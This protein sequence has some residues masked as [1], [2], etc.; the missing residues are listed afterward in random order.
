MDVEQVGEG[1]FVFVEEMLVKRGARDEPAAVDGQ[2]LH[3]RV[4][5]GRQGDF[6]VVQLH[7]AGGG[8]D[9]HPVDGEAG[10]RLGAGAA[11]HRPEAGK[12]F[13]EVEGL[14]DII[15]G[16]MVEPA[17]PVPRAIAGCEHDDGSALAEAEA[18]QHGPTIQPGQH[19]IE[20]DRVIVPGEGFIEAIETVFS[21]VHG[22][23]FL[24]QRLG[25]A[26]QEVGFV[27]D[28]KQAHGG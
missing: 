28:E 12:E 16:P 10:R 2:I 17:D 13:R 6:L 5:A 9:F 21:G 27:F 4:F 15:I 19:A 8:V 22:V 26:V 3:Q 1:A 14:D 24:A 25:E 11:D 20:D 18:L 23:A 7:G